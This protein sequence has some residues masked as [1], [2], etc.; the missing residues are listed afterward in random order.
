MFSIESGPRLCVQ[1]E[2]KHDAELVA[3]AAANKLVQMQGVVEREKM[4]GKE[5]EMNG[6]VNTPTG[7]TQEQWNTML[8]S[9]GIP[10]T[11]FSPERAID[12]AH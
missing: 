1:L 10:S 6:E 3:E 12:S 9:G 8:A 11:I 5:V 4:K 2:T 7:A